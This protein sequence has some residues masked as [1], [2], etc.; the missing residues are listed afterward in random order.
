M[1]TLYLR[2]PSPQS[3][4]PDAGHGVG[5]EWLILDGDEVA[6]QGGSLA[7]LPDAKAETAWL[8]N[9]DNVVALVP[10]ADVLAIACDI[11]GR[12]P[13]EVRRA[14]PFAVEEHLTEDIETMHVAT[15]DIVRGHAIACLAVRRAVLD[16][17][18]AALSDA[19][20]A[21][22]FLTTDAMALAD[23]PG[24]VTVFH[25]HDRAL[26]RAGDEVASVDR[27]LLPA[28][29]ES[30]AEGLGGESQPTLLEVNG[31]VGAA[32]GALSFAGAR[33]LDAGGLEYLARA[34]G[35]GEHAINLLQGDLTPRRGG[36]ASFR[37]WRATAGLAAAALAVWVASL[38][39]EGWWANTQSEAVREQAVAVYREIY[40][41]DRIQ[42]D[43]TSRMRREL[44]E[45]TADGD[46]GVRPLIGFLGSGLAETAG[47][48]G[49][50]SLTYSAGRGLAADVTVADY[51]ALER[52]E[53]DLADR[54][55]TLAIASAE[56]DGAR[57]HARLRITAQ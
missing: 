37:P 42:G 26:V 21:P 39:V 18:L 34:F 2:L 15:G 28:V 8:G 38:L 4:E 43:P 50:E 56:Q 10:A 40:G 41:G 1:P 36:R 51:G 48:Y 6:G 3:P 11:P 54:G 46:P 27:S 32:L 13:A 31:S 44:G 25:E 16:A 53:E 55:A 52:L 19:G 49:L 30:L 20:V 47:D 33:R 22:G 23:E 29:L 9:H 57:V 45:T 12:S 14:A 24:L 17:W 5:A 7:E 35:R